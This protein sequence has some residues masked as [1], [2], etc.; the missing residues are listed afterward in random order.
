MGMIPVR[1]TSPIVGLIPTI[2]FADDGHTMEPS[3]S[4]PIPATQKL[5]ETAAPVPELEPHGFRSSAYG[6]LVWPP[7]PLHPLLE[8]LERMF[9]HSERLVL[10]RMTAPACRNLCATCESCGAI[11]PISTSE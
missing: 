8:W 10:P 11:D 6:F 1:L 7:R 5:P 4:E 9:A 3:V 2:P